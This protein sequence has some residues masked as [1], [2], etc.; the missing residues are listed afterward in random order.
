M[1]FDFRA[2]PVRA[3]EL[4]VA[5]QQRRIER[6]GERHVSAVI[7]GQRRAQLPDSRE[8]LAMRVPLDDEVLKIVE[9]LL[10][11]FRR[12]VFELNQPPQRLSDLYIEQMRRMQPFIG[13]KEPRA[14]LR[15]APGAKQKL[16]QRRGV[17]D[18]Q[19]RSRSAR[20]TPAGDVLPW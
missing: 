9:S 1:H 13:R 12:D 11:A 3:A 17:D 4:G 20:T 10:G 14:E 16:E 2:M 7:G 19:R 6:F 15:R 8:Q 5:G 18:D